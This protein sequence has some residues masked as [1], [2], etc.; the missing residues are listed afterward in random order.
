MCFFSLVLY[1]CHLCCI[2]NFIWLF[3]YQYLMESR[4]I[5]WETPV[6]VTS[7]NCC[8]QFL[9]TQQLVSL[10]CCLTL[11]VSFISKTLPF[12]VQWTLS[13]LEINLLAPELFFFNFNTPVYKIWL[14]QEPN[15]L[16]LWNKLH[17]EEKKTRRIYH[18]LNI[19]Y[20][21]LLNKYIKCNV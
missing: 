6:Y 11:Q 4:L 2:H 15:T 21:Y 16:E 17:F 1:T 19:Q 14:I 3:H 9:F 7:R 13:A 12:N 20:L 5:Q 8:R 18:V 10:H